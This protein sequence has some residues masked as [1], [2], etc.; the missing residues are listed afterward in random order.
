MRP[1]PTC[2]RYLSLVLYIFLSGGLIL[3]AAPARKGLLNLRQPD[4]TQVQAYLSGDEY[5][6]LVMTPDGCSLV[7]DAEGWWCYARYD[8]YG[9]R[10]NSG[11][12]A[13]DP[14]TP[15]EVIAASCN[16]PRGLLRQKRA[17]RLNRTIPLRNRELARTRSFQAESAGGIRHGLIILA[18]FQDLEFKYGRNDFERLINGSEATTA[19]S[20]FKDQ[21][22]DG[23]TFKFDIWR[24]HIS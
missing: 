10:L 13:G 16:I 21:W 17:F 24:L 8:F 18:Q 5:G 3:S 2:L 4:G 20:Y 6:H 1:K 15:G 22:K 11:E 23:Y 9:H 19:L 12:H 7:Q 14:E